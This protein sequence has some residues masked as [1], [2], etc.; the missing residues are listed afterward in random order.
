VLAPRDLA[1]LPVFARVAR[2][3]SFTAAAK[4]LGLSKSVVSEHVSALE[5][6]CGLRLLERSTRRLRLTQAGE[7]VLAA[8]DRAMDAV[9]DVA[10]V[11]EEHRSAPV[12]TLRIATTH[13][14]GP[15]LVAPVA[16]ALAAKHPALYVEVVADD[17]RRDLIADG[18]DVGVRLGAPLDSGYGLRRFDTVPEVI[19]AA[20]AVAARH[21]SKASPADLAGAPWVRHSLLP[22]GETIVF[23][24]SPG[25]L[26]VAVKFRAE[27]NTGDGVRGLIL[28]GAGL[29]L[30]PMHIAADDLQRRTLVRLC[31]LWTARQ[32]AIFAVLPSSRRPPRRVGLFLDALVGAL[33][34][35]RHLVARAW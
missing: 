28:G 14:L 19:V 11:V 24:G 12:G 8:T 1:L 32:V 3:G 27:A 22:R 10:R 20:P 29:G 17:V 23:T 35:E 7:Q 16:A 5:E 25:E 33:D 31:P 21:A 34:E 4:E 6:R 9:D 18:F 26:R 2:M 30:L 15:R 13:D